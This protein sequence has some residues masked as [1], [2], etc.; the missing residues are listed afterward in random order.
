MKSAIRKMGNSLG[1]II[2]TP[3][4]A[5]VGSKEGDP[6][7][8]AVK[9]GKIVIIP[10]K[11]DP[12]VNWAAECKS[13]ADAGEDGLVWP[14]FPNEDDKKLGVVMKRRSGRCLRN[15]KGARLTGCKCVA[16]L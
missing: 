9:S 10:I 12:R 13:L 7:D 11:T 16:T 3:V 4:L 15:G 2:P 6:V 5:E 14:E 8:V 1:V